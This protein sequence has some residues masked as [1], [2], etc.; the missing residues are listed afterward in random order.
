MPKGKKRCPECDVLISARDKTCE[1]GHTFAKGSDM[2]FGYKQCPNCNKLIGQ[3]SHRCKLCQWDYDLKEVVEKH[4]DLEDLNFDRRKGGVRLVLTPAG[5][6]P[7]K[8][9]DSD[10][11]EHWLELII[12]Y[13]DRLDS[14]ELGPS[15]IKYWAASVW[16]RDSDEFIKLS[17]LINLEY[18][19]QPLVKLK[20][21]IRAINLNEGAKF[22][23]YSGKEGTVIS[24][25]AGGIT[26]KY[27][28]SG[29]KSQISNDSSVKPL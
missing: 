4:S 28:I 8:H 20:G 7:V 2:P 18:N 22:V 6:C 3:R 14:A 21:C 5:G 1:C 9:S 25:T 10:S 16:G 29:R 26:V 15:A 19:V 24:K 23:D 13:S 17:E 11:A 27:R 12:D